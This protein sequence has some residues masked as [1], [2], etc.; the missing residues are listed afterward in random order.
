VLFKLLA[1]LLRPSAGEIIVDGKARGN[2]FLENCGMMIET[3]GFIGHYSGYKNLDIINSIGVKRA[4]KKRICEL[5]MTMNLDPY[6]N[7]SVSK[8]SL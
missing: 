1:G 7:K 3:P 4:S 8:F 2:A 5:M 6:S